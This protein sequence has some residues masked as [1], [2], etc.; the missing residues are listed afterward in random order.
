[1][2][3]AIVTGATS[4]IGLHL[5]NK[6]IRE[7]WKV[8]AIVRRGSSKTALLP[9]S[10]QIEIVY[11]DMNEY[12]KMGEHIKEP[13]DVYVSLAWN[14]TRGETRSDARKQEENY[15]Y[16]IDALKAVKQ[17]GCKMIISAGSQAEYG[18]MQ[19]K[20]S[21]D[22]ACKPNTEYGIWK[23]KYYEEG[24]LFCKKHGISFKEPRFFSLYGADDNEKTMI[25]S[26]LDDM[27]H[28]RPCKMTQCIQLW[29]FLYIE[30]A[31]D[32]VFRLMNTPCADGAYNFGTGDIR[33]LKEFIMEMYQITNSAS[34]LLFGSVPYPLTGMVNVCPDIK[35]LQTQTGWRAETSFAD[36]IRKIIEYRAMI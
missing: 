13:C 16:S 25:L 36:G 20:V 5:L 21:E 33:P 3:K 17:I 7:K 29:D 2:K 4:F 6:L 18:P 8:Y 27:M 23:L 28:N 1:M 12:S 22:D 10:E 15:Q 11:L 24:M 32:G 31:I 14:G 30:D 34:P 9:S 35:K 19:D 26:I